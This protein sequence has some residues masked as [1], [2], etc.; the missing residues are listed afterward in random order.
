MKKNEYWTVRFEKEFKKLGRGGYWGWPLST[1][2]KKSDV[3]RY[4]KK[5]I[6]DG[7]VTLVKVRIEEVKK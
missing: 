3:K 1:P 4:W 7:L 5:C 6:K 2:W